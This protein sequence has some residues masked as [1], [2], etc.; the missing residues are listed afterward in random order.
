MPPSPH[1]RS[2]HRRAYLVGVPGQG[3]F[4]FAGDGAADRAPGHGGGIA[5]LGYLEVHVDGAGRRG[6]DRGAAGTE[7]PAEPVPVDVHQFATVGGGHGD[8]TGVGG[9]TGDQLQVAGVDGG[10]GGVGGG[11]AGVIGAV[12]EEVEGGESAD[13]GGA[14]QAGTREEDPAVDGTCVRGGGA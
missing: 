8:A 4:P 5:V 2:L 1:S 7:V 9:V 14:G 3:E 13:G 12:R 11:G 6:V 10:R